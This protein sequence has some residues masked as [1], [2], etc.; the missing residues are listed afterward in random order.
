MLLML[1]STGTGKAG[2]R[3]ASTVYDAAPATALHENGKL[4]YGWYAVPNGNGARTGAAS[5]PA[6]APVTTND[7]AADQ[8]L[9]SRA[10]LTAWTCQKYV[11]G[12]SPPTTADVVCGFVE[13][14]VTSDAN[15]DVLLICQL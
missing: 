10:A 11:P 5:E 6:P 1:R 8:E 3:L 15:V 12:S 13:S 14:R 2:S 4:S 9:L 7:R